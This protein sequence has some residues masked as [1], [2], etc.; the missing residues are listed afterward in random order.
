MLEPKKPGSDKP[1]DAKSADKS[2]G[3]TKSADKKK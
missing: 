3:G 1:A 2:A